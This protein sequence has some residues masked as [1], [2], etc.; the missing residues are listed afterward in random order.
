MAST[1]NFFLHKSGF[2]FTFSQKYSRPGFFLGKLDQNSI[3]KNIWERLRYETSTF[4]NLCSFEK[5][6]ETGFFQGFPKITLYLNF[7]GKIEP[8][9]GR[10]LGNIDLNF[11]KFVLI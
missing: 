10:C 11:S 1:E 7:F 5:S 3:W 6:H 9:S 2:S 4:P 8:Q